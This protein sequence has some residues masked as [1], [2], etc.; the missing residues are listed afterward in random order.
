M[1]E[2]GEEEGE[3]PAMLE[4]VNESDSAPVQQ[5]ETIEET[6][7]NN[8]AAGHHRAEAQA[9]HFTEEEDHGIMDIGI[10][11]TKCTHRGR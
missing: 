5:D 2:V 3:E 1:A 4:S 7:T 8:A 10:S 9:S 6:I 11:K